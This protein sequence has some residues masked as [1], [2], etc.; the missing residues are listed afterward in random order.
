T[1]RDGLDYARKIILTLR[2]SGK[3]VLFG[4]VRINLEYCSP[5]VREAILAEKTPLGRVLI[6][7]NVLRRIEPLA[8]FRVD[9]GLRQLAWFGLD[10]PA[11]LY[12]RLG[13]IHCDEQPAVELLEI[14]T[15][16]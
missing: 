8:Y 12:G 4:I 11:P 10:Q 2:G 6:E 5:P 7:H 13:F 14:V 9:P 1:Y 16:K 3:V 15:A